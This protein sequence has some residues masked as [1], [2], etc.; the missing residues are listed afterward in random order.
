MHQEGDAWSQSGKRGPKTT[1]VR[2]SL[3]ANDEMVIE[4]GNGEIG[5]SKLTYSEH[6][7]AGFTNEGSLESSLTVVNPGASFDPRDLFKVQN[8]VV[9][10]QR[11]PFRIRWVKK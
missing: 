3:T 8:F 2:E 5:M 10:G 7:F 11:V 4:W 9:D 6:A 1:G